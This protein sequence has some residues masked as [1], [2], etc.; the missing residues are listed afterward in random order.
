MYKKIAAILA[1]ASVMAA[2]GAALAAPFEINEFGASAQFTY[3][4]ANSALYLGHLGC[5]SI[6]GPTTFSYNT[7]GTGN[8]VKH[9][10]AQ[11]AGCTSTKIPSTNGGQVI[12]RFTGIASGEGPL[13]LN[14]KNPIE[15]DLLNFPTHTDSTACSAA[16]GQRAQMTGSGTTLGCTS[17]NLGASDVNV[18]SINQSVDD[19]VYT[20][21]GQVKPNFADFIPAPGTTTLKNQA[22]EVPFAFYANNNV[23]AHHCLDASGNWIGQYCRTA[24]DCVNPNGSQFGAGVTCQATATHITNVSRL[25]AVMLFSGQVPTWKWFGDSFGATATGGPGTS[26]D[27]FTKIC[28]RVPGSGTIATLD[29]TVMTAG[30]TGWGS[31]VATLPSNDQTF[32][33]YVQFNKSTGDELNCVAATTQ[34]DVDGTTQTVGAIGYADCDQAKAGT[35]Q[36]TYQGVLCSAANIRNGLYDFYSPA[37]RYYLNS[38]YTGTALNMETD[39]EA[40]LSL[41]T[42]IPGTERNWWTV[43]SEKWYDRGAV[44]QYPIQV[45]PPTNPSLP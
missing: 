24:A 18:E 25:Q 44:T 40:Y 9:G 34:L 10:F 6:T 11:G 1:G 32:L 37:H 29:K 2:A 28:H 5:T 12:I 14:K 7:A 38:Y 3:W 42:N 19:S 8:T 30:A 39:L 17:I 23:V 41:P 4:Q 43:A 21:T 15:A 31:P 45:G 36:L 20:L 22:F 27:L 13:A 26:G 16:S 33:P 35:T